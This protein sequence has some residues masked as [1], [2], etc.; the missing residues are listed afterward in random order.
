MTIEYNDPASILGEFV[1]ED[2]ERRGTLG[3]F[4]GDDSGRP[5]Y[6]SAVVR[7]LLDDG[8]AFVPMEP[9][10]NCK[11]PCKLCPRRG[12]RSKA[13]R[14]FTIR[15]AFTLLAGTDYGMTAVDAGILISRECG[16]SVNALRLGPLHDPPVDPPT[17]GTIQALWSKRKKRGAEDP[18]KARGELVAGRQIVLRVLADIEACDGV[19]L[20]VREIKGKRTNRAVFL[21]LK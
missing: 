10:C 3:E 6:V 9:P 5:D 12:W 21:P 18:W 7:E 20:G 13:R 2:G 1:D 4:A 19:R 14:D 15:R 8:L 17:P 11:K 16:L